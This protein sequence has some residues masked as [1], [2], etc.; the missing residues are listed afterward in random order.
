MPQPRLI[1]LPYDASSSYLRGPAEAPPLIRAALH[2]THWNSWTELG[3]DLSVPGALTDAGDLPLSPDISARDAIEA[4][5]AAVLAAG[6]RPRPA[7]PL[8]WPTARDRS[9]SAATT[10]SPTLSS[11]PSIGDIRHSRSCTSTPI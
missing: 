10:R 11:G 1:G 5:I 6:A 7:S 4:G 3:Q 8:C 2:S 9:H